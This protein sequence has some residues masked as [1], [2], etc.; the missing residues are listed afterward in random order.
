MAYQDFTGGWCA[1][2]SAMLHPDTFATAVSLGGYW[3][4]DFDPSFVPFPP[5]SAEQDKYDLISLAHKRPASSCVAL[6][7]LYGKSDV[8]AAPTSG[9][10]MAAVTKPT[11]LTTIVLPRGGHNTAVWLPYVQPSLEWLAG[12]SPD[13]R[14]S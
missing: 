6:W 3:Q 2:M 13:F 8:L 4:P 14:A 9:A 12:A 11:S 7:T 5:G 10:M 1:N